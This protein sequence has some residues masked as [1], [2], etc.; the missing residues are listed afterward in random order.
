MASS[1][2]F[3][4]PW[5]PTTFIILSVIHFTAYQ[6]SFF[7]A[8]PKRKGRGRPK[9]SHVQ[10]EV[11]ES[12][13]GEF[14]IP[15]IPLN[16]LKADPDFIEEQ[17]GG[18]ILPRKKGRG[19]PKG[20]RAQNCQVH[21]NLNSRINPSNMVEVAPGCEE[22]EDEVVPDKNGQERPRG[23]RGQYCQENADYENFYSNPSNM[24]EVNPG[25]DMPRKGGLWQPRESIN[26]EIHQQN[27]D[28]IIAKP[29]RKGRGQTKGLTL[30]MK[31][32]QSADG[33]LDVLI[34]PTKLVAVG[35]G[36]NDFITDL[37]L[38][39]R[40]NARLN[41]RQWKKV[42]QSTRDTIVQNIL[43]NWRLPDT[44]MVRKAIL[45]EAGRLYQNWRSRL[46]E[47]YLKFETKEEALKHVPDDIYDSDWQFLV[48]YFSSPYFEIIS[49]K[50]K[51]N[52]AKHR[53]HHTTGS[54]S[55][56]AVSYDARDPVTGKE[57]DLQTF[58]QLTHKR[59][60]G[61]WIDEASKEINDKVAEQ[62]NEKRCQIE[63]S[64][65]VVE[66]MEQEII[67]TAFKTVVGKE[68]FMQGFGA[69][70]RS[71]SSS[72][73]RIQQLQAELDAQKR[74]TENAGKECN[75][76]KAKLVE[77]ESCL[78]EERLKCKEIEARLLD[79]QSEMQEISSQVQTTIQAAL[80][81]YLPQKTE[82][83]TS[84]KN[85]RKIAEIEAQLHEAENV[86]TDI[87]SELIRY[88]MG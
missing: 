13:D 48:D 21:G 62:I 29:K 79:R 73:G 14:A 33:K 22:P 63:D 46:H 24:M 51:A 34:H 47:Y 56:L 23:S 43:N 6:N 53:I 59:D 8:M 40:Q 35:P 57:P 38:I 16:G 19:R 68:S 7:G 52:K 3:I 86:I 39:V 50:N 61:E 41:V 77:V 1:S 20:S 75:E 70:L 84:S 32:Q 66:T 71:S 78:E 88:R 87:R 64:Q 10:K 80:S 5:M 12:A 42:P 11:K 54:K 85:K 55:F 30:Q 83:E 31:R 76:I 4:S 74:E 69:G 26:Q 18:S 60:N 82:A 9:G 27:A 58:W 49:S 72:S 25:F 65:E 36:R 2:F 37:S 81:Q 28:D 17:E 67:N 45:C 15:N 44:D